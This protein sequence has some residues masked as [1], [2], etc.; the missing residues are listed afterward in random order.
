M[1]GTSSA[2]ATRG[3]KGQEGKSKGKNNN[4]KK[5]PKKQDNIVDDKTCYVVK[6]GTTPTIGDITLGPILIAKGKSGPNLTSSWNGTLEREEK[7]KQRLKPTRGRGK[8]GI[9][10]PETWNETSNNK[11][12]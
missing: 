4:F 2:Q 12:K 10:T 1:E 11:I 9:K 3:E 5:K 8:K 6:K 7:K